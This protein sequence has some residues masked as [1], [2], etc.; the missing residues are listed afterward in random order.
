MQLCIPTCRSG[1]SLAARCLYARESYLTISTDLIRVMTRVKA[2]YR[3]WG[4]PCRG[5]QVY[6]D[7]HRAEWLGKI[8]EAG[9]RRR[10]A[11][12]HQQVATLRLP[13]PERTPELPAPA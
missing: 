1:S 3:S 9:V 11:F 4:I 12:Y 6:A 7:R 10:A 5:K 8:P 13:R 2:I